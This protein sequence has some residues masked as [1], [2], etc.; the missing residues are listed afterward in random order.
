MNPGERGRAVHGECAQGID[1]LRVLPPDQKALGRIAEPAVGVFQLADGGV[2]MIAV[3]A[4]FYIGQTRLGSD[5]VDP[6]LIVAAEELH[7]LLQFIGDPF[8]VLDNGTIHIDYVECAVGP[9]PHVDRAGMSVGSGE[10]LDLVSG[11]A[12][13][14]DRSVGL[15]LVMVDDVKDGVGHEQGIVELGGE[16]ASAVEGDAAGTG[17]V[18]GLFRVIESAFLFSDGISAVEVARFVV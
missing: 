17:E 14:E 11:A 4:G 2:D 8:R 5:A 13:A 9:D 10:E 7:V 16:G 1:R 15:E 12:G 3:K 6:A 18:A